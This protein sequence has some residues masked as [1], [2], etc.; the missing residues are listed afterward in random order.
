MKHDVDHYFEGYE[1]RTVLKENGKEKSEFVYTGDYYRIDMDKAG[2]RKIKIKAISF[3]AAFIAMFI[4]AGVM[5]SLGNT[6]GWTGIASMVMLIPA[7]YWAI[8]TVRFVTAGEFMESRKVYY[9]KNRMQRSLT[10]VRVLAACQIIV[11]IISVI[12]YRDMITDIPLEIIFTAI[13]AAENILVWFAKK[14][15]DSIEVDNIG[16]RPKITVVEDP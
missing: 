6:Y 13:L 14:S 1:K 2:L 10:G 12:V 15:I 16:K 3:L 5:H 8:G 4:A 9:G 7:I 11:E